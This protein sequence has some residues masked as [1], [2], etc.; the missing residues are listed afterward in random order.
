MHAATEGRPPPRWVRSFA[1]VSI[2]ASAVAVVCLVALEVL[3]DRW[4]GLDCGDGRTNVLQWIQLTSLTLAALAGVSG[5]I[6]LFAAGARRKIY[7]VTGMAIAA[8]VVALVWVIPLN[9]A[10]GPL[11]DVGQ[12]VC[13]TTTV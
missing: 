9:G 2:L 3:K 7:A 5:L 10:E 8:C 6:G 13:G 12:V 11:G 1:V 4:G